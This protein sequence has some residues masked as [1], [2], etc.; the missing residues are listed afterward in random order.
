[1]EYE[2]KMI[3]LKDGID[4]ETITMFNELGKDGWKLVTQDQL[5]FIFIRE[6]KIDYSLERFEIKDK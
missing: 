1:M 2:Y 5:H 3:Y 4:N 6:N